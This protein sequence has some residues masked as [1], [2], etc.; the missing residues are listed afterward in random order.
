MSRF[1]RSVF[2]VRDCRKWMFLLALCWV[3]GLL[4]GCLCGGSRAGVFPS[5]M[6]LSEFGQVDP[7]GSL[8]I[9]SLPFVSSVIA[10][11][12]WRSVLPLIAF[13]KAFCFAYVSAGLMVSFGSAG[14]LVCI[15]LLLGD[16]AMLPLLWLYWYRSM[17]GQSVAA[18]C[19]AG[20]LAMVIWWFD[21]AV[22]S[23]FVANMI[24]C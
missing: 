21:Y 4:L 13:A 24:F 2:A 3:F 11:S 7:F 18:I 22:L 1:F 9:L 10:V 16:G 12:L 23:P 19:I 5:N 15:L 6:E 17:A 20:T 14:W 8:L